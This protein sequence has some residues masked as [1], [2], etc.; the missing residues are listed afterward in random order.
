MRKAGKD[1]KGAL[2][3]AIIAGSNEAIISTEECKLLSHGGPHT[4]LKIL[5]IV[6]NGKDN[7]T[8]KPTEEKRQPW[9]LHSLAQKDPAA[10]T[11][12][13]GDHLL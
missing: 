13:L 4:S 10:E 7:P 1:V 9:V 5:P 11:T 12:L 6:I 8:L 2:Q 3:L